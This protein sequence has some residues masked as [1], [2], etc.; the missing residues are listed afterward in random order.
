MSHIGFILSLYQYPGYVLIKGSK[1]LN[2]QIKLKACNLFLNQV[3]LASN[4]I[5]TELA[6]T[7][8]MLSI[9]QTKGG[10]EL[11][12]NKFEKISGYSDGLINLQTKL[13]G[14]VVI[15]LNKFFNNHG[16]L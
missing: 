14:P 3:S 1:F 10:L 9:E 2:T 5:F 16:T 6:S 7:L 8:T 15:K 12:N 11:I 13:E 4:S